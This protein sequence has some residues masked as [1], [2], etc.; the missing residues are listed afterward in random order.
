MIRK[1]AQPLLIKPPAAPPKQKQILP[2]MPKPPTSPKSARIRRNFI[3]RNPRVQKYHSI[4]GAP[5]SPNNVIKFHSNL[6]TR[7]EKTEIVHYKE[8]YFIRNE[9]IQRDILQIDPEYFIFTVNEHIRYRYQQLEELGRGSFGSVLK[10]YDH[11]THKLVAVKLVRDRPKIH[12]QVLLEKEVFDS[13][14]TP[15]LYESFFYR[16][17][18]GF[19]FELLGIDIYT[20]IKN[21]KFQGLDPSRLHIVSKNVIEAL[22]FIHSLGFVHCDLKPENIL[23]STPRKTNA[24]LIDYGCCCRIGSPLFQYI[25]SRFYRAPEVIIGA[26][27]GIEIDIWSF[28][29]VLHEM[30]TGKVLFPGVDEKQQ[31]G[32]YVAALGQPTDRDLEGASRLSEFYNEDK[33]LKVKVDMKPLVELLDP[34]DKL[35]NDLIIRCLQWHPDDRITIPQIMEHPYMKAVY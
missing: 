4:E 12:K 11:K 13:I 3:N 30:K 34:C 2:Q 35:L 29:C 17:F 25:Q 16:G 7:Q 32:M 31:F 21:N 28:G 9:P 26:P 33:T 19:V 24:R 14:K 23:W 10:C 5:L 15:I 8:I 22:S 27:Y 20:T 6:L 1:K 18:Y